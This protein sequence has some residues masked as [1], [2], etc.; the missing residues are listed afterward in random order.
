MN[1]YDIKDPSFLKSL[2]T[3]EL[4]ALAE[5]IRSFL[6]GSISETGGHLSSNLG[7]IELTIALHYVFDSPKDALIFDVGHQTYTHKILTGR[8]NEFGTLRQT[9]GLS[10]YI[11]YKESVHDQ[12]ESGHA[13]TALSALLGVL[14]AKH[15]KNE[16]GEGVAVVGDASITSGMSFEAL[17]LLGSDK[18]TRGIII[19]NDNEMS[20]SKSVGSISK[21]L[22]RFRSNKLFIKMKR[23]WQLILPRFVLG[24]LSRIKRGLRGFLQRQNIFEDLGYMYIG[25]LDGHDIKSLI[26]NLTRIRKIKKSVVLH[27]ITEKGKGHQEASNDKVGTFHGVS[28][29]GTLKKE[30]VS[31]SELISLT[32]DQLQSVKKTFVVMPAMTVGAQFIEFAKKYPD[33]YLDVGIAEEHAATMSASLA[34]QGIPVFLPLYAT[35]AQRAFDQILN[36]IS[37][38]NHHVVFGIDRAGIVGEDGST[39]QG[40]FDISMFNLMPNFVITMPYNAKE[41]MNLLYYGFMKQSH[42]I[43]IRYPRGTADFNKNNGGITFDEIEATWTVLSEGETI[44]LI[45]YG[46]SLDL[47]LEAKDEMKLSAEVVNARFIK[48]IDEEMLHS[49]CKSGNPIL[50]YEEQSNMGSLY[51]QILKFMAKFNY[52]NQIHEM[53]ITDKVVE[54]GNYRDMLKELEMDKKSIINKIKGMLS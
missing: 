15:L 6:I 9:N 43:V 27:I 25:P 37:R 46:P 4:K 16:E 2:K 29:A 24:F 49:I 1:L 41:A 20:I 28:K 21:A 31:W 45:S 17:N 44:T 47:L 23:M 33:R 22:T 48:P 39:H 5:E 14:Y 32:L 18:N 12:W 11:N 38:S 36:D 26:Y 53:S 40:L 50:V 51:P 30:N 10:G 42:P 54:H 13:G 52:K 34:H 3:K 19:L 8:I 7:T 35:F